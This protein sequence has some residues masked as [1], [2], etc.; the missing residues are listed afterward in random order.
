MTDATLLRALE[1]VATLKRDEPL[2]RH[3]T[4]GIG[5][6]PDAY[7]A[8]SDGAQLSS[9]LSLCTQAGT[10]VFVL[11][12][13]SNIVVG[14][15][16]IRAVVIENR[17]THISEPQLLS[18][19]AIKPSPSGGRGLGEGATPGSATERYLIRA[20]AGASFAQVSR[21]LSFEGL[22]GLEWACGIPGTIGGAVVY[23]AGAYGGCLGDVLQRIAVFDP[24]APKGERVIEAADLGLVYRGSAFTRGLMAGRSVL[25]A[26]FA[27]WPGEEA[28]L[29]TRIAE[30][31]GRRLKAQPRGRN[32][33]SFFKNPPDH[34]AWR[35]LD[36]VGMRGYQLGGAQFSDKHCNFLINAGNATAADVAA[37]KSE[38]QR[39]VLEQHGLELH[40][41]VTLVGEGF[42][43]A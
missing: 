15:N 25:W 42:G 31:D 34:P 35:L 14:D 19:D 5:G 20:D 29:R 39:R 22:A 12:S 17:A 41:E 43:D 8:V 32:A 6:I 7:V 11:G 26:E 33:G 9:V 10:P 30:Y 21:H 28:E 40:N 3:T 36:S 1:G 16:G 4:I 13:G 27:L 2:S 24:D 37:I 18:Q 23:N 38:A